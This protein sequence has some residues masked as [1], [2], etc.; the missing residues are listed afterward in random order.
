MEID[1]Q[2]AKHISKQKWKSM[3][4]DKIGKM[5]KIQFEKEIIESERYAGIAIDDVTPGK[6][7]KY[8]DI[9]RKLWVQYSEVEQGF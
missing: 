7:K 8:M 5:I 3:I 2:R 6:P 4:K 9:N 1:L